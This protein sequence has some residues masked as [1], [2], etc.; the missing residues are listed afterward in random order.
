MNDGRRGFYI[1]LA[2]GV[3]LGIL[4]IVLLP[5]VTL[6]IL[7][8]SAPA[9]VVASAFATAYLVRVFQRQ[10]RP[11]SR[12]FRMLVET[13]VGLLLV[14]AWVTYLSVARALA[15]LAEDGHDVWVPPSPPVSVSA[16]VSA[17]IVTAVFLVPVRFAVTVYRA[18]REVS[19]DELSL[20]RE[21]EPRQK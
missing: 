8:I 12:F 7:T 21:A 1:R 3:L 11:R 16:P 17:L 10:P 4:G 13:F 6:L 15:R 20:D 2:L 5:D 18:R 19:S 14:G 9:A